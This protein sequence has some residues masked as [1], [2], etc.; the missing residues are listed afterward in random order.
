MA[1][2]FR[3]LD[4]EVAIGQGL[5]RLRGLNRAKAALRSASLMA[6]LDFAT[7]SPL[8]IDSAGANAARVTLYPNRSI[9]AGLM[10]GRWRRFVNFRG[11]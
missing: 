3:S 6:P 11:W 8:K 5:E 10:P 2:S 7:F 1:A 4:D 9:A